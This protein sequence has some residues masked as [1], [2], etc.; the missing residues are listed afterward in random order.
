[1]AKGITGIILAF[2]RN[3]L[4]FYL[5][6]LWLYRLRLPT[7]LRPEPK[8]LLFPL[9][10]WQTFVFW[11]VGLIILWQFCLRYEKLKRAYP[12]FLQYI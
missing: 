2:G 10:M 1:L 3:P 7:G 9:E 8:S 11:I 12:R 6:H 5:T 4:F